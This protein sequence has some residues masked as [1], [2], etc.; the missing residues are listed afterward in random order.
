MTDYYLRYLTADGVQVLNVPD[1]SR[2]EYTLAENEVGVLELSLPFSQFIWPPILDGRFEVYR[3]V[4][5]GAYYLDGGC[6][7]LL[8]DWALEKSGNES[9]ISLRAYH[10]NH[11]LGRRIVAYNADTS[12]TA[13]TDYIDDMMKEIVYENYLAGA[14]AARNISAYMTAQA[15][16]SLAPRVSKAFSRRNVLAILQELAQLS[17]ENGTYLVFDAVKTGDALTEFR[18]YT[19]QRGVNRGTTGAAPLTVSVENDGLTEPVLAYAY[20]DEIN[21]IYAGGKGEG[22]LR[23]IQEA[24]DAVRLA[25]SALNRSEYFYDARNG[26]DDPA[27]LLSEA[28]E[29]LAERRPRVMFDAVLHENRNLLYGIHYNWGDIVTAQYQGMVFDCHVDIVNVRVG[30]GEETVTAK[31]HGE[32]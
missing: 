24:S 32:V 16:L 27:D 2:L 14:V 13:K 6:Q 23:V 12:Q 15:D 31:I 9:I 26:S 22:S 4:G 28:E 8:R 30:G 7:W 25:A 11:L 5:A 21:Y 1:F 3:R 10:T 17:Y 29:Q 20:A 19:G 18:T